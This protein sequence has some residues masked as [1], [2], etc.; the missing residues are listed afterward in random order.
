MP[1]IELGIVLSAYDRTQGALEQLTQGG[2]AV[3][4]QIV[5]LGKAMEGG[6]TAGREATKVMRDLTRELDANDKA[7][8]LAGK[9][10][11]DQFDVLNAGIEVGDRV[12][13]SF[14]RGLRMMTQY[15]VA[16][17]R[18]T[19]AE[20]AQRA[21][22]D[23]LAW[24]REKL[25]RALEAEDEEGVAAATKEVAKAQEEFEKVTQRA[26]DA[27]NQLNIMLLGFVAQAPAF[28]KDFMK[29]GEA[30]AQFGTQIKYA[31][32]LGAVFANAIGGMQ[33]A[34][35][36]FFTFL[37]AN[38]V[39]LV[40]AA[41]VA[42]VAALYLAW[43]TDFMGMRKPIEDFYNGT[44]V[45][46]VG[47]LSDLFKTFWDD[48]LVP[49]GQAFAEVWKD[50]IGPALKWTWDTILAPTLGAI[51]SGLT[52]VIGWIKDA[53]KW[54]H[55][56]IDAWTHWEPDPKTLQIQQEVMGPLAAVGGMPGAIP[57]GQFGLSVKRSGLYYL[58]EGEE[59]SRGAK[60]GPINIY[61]ETYQG[62]RAAGR[63]FLDELRNMGVYPW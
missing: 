33:A 52:T 30:V 17:V 55:D 36:G 26:T 15:N 63:G 25:A 22:A 51:I 34:A 57:S 31:G 19:Q 43:E 5:E 45:P 8:R 37:L 20:E 7:A 54:I 4:D 35:S 56:I 11:S 13:K 18:V 23:K 2:K 14:D 10:W 44:V 29:T 38:P 24:A 50:V 16:Q 9:A 53:I 28:A 42:A 59:V 41:I 1:E 58:H 47:A 6:G 12:A 39:V 46:I 61:A 3:Q 32:G 40:I 62:G 21:A 49:L 48:V 27:Q 60:I